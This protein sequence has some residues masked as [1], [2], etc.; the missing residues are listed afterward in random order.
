M[1]LQQLKADVLSAFGE[2]ARAV[3]RASKFV[4]VALIIGGALIAAVALGIDI[5]FANGEISAWTIAGIF[6]A[7]AVAIGSLFDAIRETDASEAL[8]KAKD[9]IDYAQ[10]REQD[11]IVRG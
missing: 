2:Y 10:E 11:L 8:V 5:A 9:A 4:K 3:Y 1:D 7:A 6:G